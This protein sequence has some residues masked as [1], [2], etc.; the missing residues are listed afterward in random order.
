M[1][2]PASSAAGT[3]VTVKSDLRY[4]KIM[5]LF[6]P[7]ACSASW[8]LYLAEEVLRAHRAGKHTCALTVR[9]EQCLEDSFSF[10]GKTVEM[11]FRSGR[12]H[13]VL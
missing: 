7:V 9:T 13:L 5:P 3:I 11:C 4:L 12:K 6:T 2:N 8:G 1:F 10:Q